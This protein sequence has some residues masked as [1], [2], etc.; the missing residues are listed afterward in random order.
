MVSLHRSKI[1]NTSV[2][3]IIR[4]LPS[5]LCLPKV[6]LLSGGHCIFDRNVVMRHFRNE[7][8]YDS[9]K[10]NNKIGIK[11][12]FIKTLISK[13]CCHKIQI[14]KKEIKFISNEAYFLELWMILKQGWTTS[15][16]RTTTGSITFYKFQ[17]IFWKR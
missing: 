8:L 11:L 4:L 12:R 14:E 15:G 7:I 5:L 16:P 17:F 10:R 9:S 2:N 13:N 1:E 6:I 3:W